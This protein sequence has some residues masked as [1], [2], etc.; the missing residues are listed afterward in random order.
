MRPRI[1]P[2]IVVDNKPI[3][4]PNIYPTNIAK[5]SEKEIGL[6]P[7]IPIIGN[8]RLKKLRIKYIEDIIEIS[9][10]YGDKVFL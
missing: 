5:D 6:A 3:S 8:P 10:I 9:E 1:N 2:P 7:S 4:Q